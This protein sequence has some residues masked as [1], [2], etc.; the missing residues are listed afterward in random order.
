MI[1]T[2]NS[3]IRITNSLTFASLIA[4]LAATPTVAFSGSTD[5]APSDQAALYA[6]FHSAEL[7]VVDGLDV[8]TR[9]LS[10]YGTPRSASGVREEA[11]IAAKSINGTSAKVIAAP[12]LDIVTLRAFFRSAAFNASDGLTVYGGDYS[13][14]GTRRPES[15]TGGLVHVRQ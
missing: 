11:L 12:Q 10:A 13:S 6:C 1:K 7:N 4:F 15:N 2:S 3:F 14:Y 8:Y 9:D 5:C